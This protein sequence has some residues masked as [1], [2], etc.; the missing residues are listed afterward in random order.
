M[1]SHVGT[2]VHKFQAE[3]SKITEHTALILVSE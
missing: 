3:F 2:S 1:L